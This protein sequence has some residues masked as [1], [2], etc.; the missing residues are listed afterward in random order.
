LALSIAANFVNSQRGRQPEFHLDSQAIVDDLQRLQF[1]AT[2]QEI[3]SNVEMCSKRKGGS[4]DARAFS[5]TLACLN[6]PAQGSE[7]KFG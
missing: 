3:I 7:V 4:E 1:S 6:I 5:E 2:A